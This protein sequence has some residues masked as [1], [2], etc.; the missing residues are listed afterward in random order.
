MQA[1][2][3]TPLPLPADALAATASE[4]HLLM[5][6]KGGDWRAAE[7]FPHTPG[8]I[9]PAYLQPYRVA[10]GAAQVQLRRAEGQAGPWPDGPLDGVLVVRTADGATLAHT[11]SVPVQRGAPALLPEAP[12]AGAEPVVAPAGADLGLWAALLLAFGGGLLLNLMPCVFPV[13]AIKT[14]AVVGQSP[15][16]RRSH[17]LGYAAGVLVSM[18]ALAGLLL[19]LRAAGQGLGWG[20][21]LQSPAFVAAMAALFFLLGLNLAG[22]FTVGGAVQ[23]GAGDLAMRLGAHDAAP[24]W[25]RHLAALADGALAVAIATPCTAPFMGAALGFALQAPPAATLGV[26]AALA[27]GLAAPV[28]VLT[29]WPALA[30]RLP[31]PGAWM[32]TLKTLFAFPLFAT[33]V[34]LVWVF[35]Q[36]TGIDAVARLLGALVLLGLAA[37]LW[38]RAGGLLPRAAGGA[39]AAVLAV[40]LAL[41]GLSAPAPEAVSASGGGTAS[42]QPW[43]PGEVAALQA[44]GRPVFVDFTAAWC[45]TC[46]V[47]KKT[48]LDTDR[49]QA[50][51]RDRGVALM[52]ADWTRRDPEITRA[53]QALG[54][55]GVPVYVLYGSDGRAR[56]LSELLTAGA[57]LQALDEAVPASAAQSPAV[58]PAS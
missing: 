56:V 34:W 19:A 1:T 22:V 18:L 13:L 42:W 40:V 16:Q 36:Q 31:R 5:T 21:Q 11:L 37:W 32:D 44:Q 2:L 50:A 55:S 15:A 25:R 9:L 54:R 52:R 14:L 51:F 20:F 24:A 7:F 38:G 47:N 4:T 27:A 57:V 35:G 46:Q 43:S 33:V 8:V 10:D 12:A 30:A 23:R 17:A 39:V 6:L 48:V 26:F 49:V 58:A 28:V 45:I 3:P 29:A 53:L 41:P